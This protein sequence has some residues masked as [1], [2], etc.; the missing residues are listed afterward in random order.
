M[1]AKPNKI[2]CMQKNNIWNPNTCACKIN[3]YLKSITDDLVIACDRIIHVMDTVSI[4]S[5]DKEATCKMNNY[6]ISYSLFISNTLSLN[7]TICYYCIK[8]QS[9]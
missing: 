9:K 7:H 1:S 5:N 3:R 2:S 4:N 8:P 6:I